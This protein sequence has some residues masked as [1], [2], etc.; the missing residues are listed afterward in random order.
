M[1]TNPFREI[2]EG[3]MELPILTPKEVEDGLKARLAADDKDEAGPEDDEPERDF[4][5]DRDKE[6]AEREDAEDHR[7]ELARFDAE[8]RGR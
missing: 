8:G 7:R 5:V 2:M 3:I 1:T 6:R 4:I